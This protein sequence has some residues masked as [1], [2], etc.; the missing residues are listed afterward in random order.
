MKIKY[1]ITGIDCPNCAGK[2]ASQIEAMEGINSAK[3]NFLTEKL[4]V[5]TTLSEADAY[6]VVCAVSRAFSK[7]IK[8]EK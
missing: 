2:L 1:T 3:I 8:V 4:T 5:D 7:S 6:E